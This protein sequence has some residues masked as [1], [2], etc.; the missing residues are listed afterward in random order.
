MCDWA[1][2]GIYAWEYADCAFIESHQSDMAQFLIK[3]K[4][5]Y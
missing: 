4:Q 5:L 1:Y 2:D 3:R